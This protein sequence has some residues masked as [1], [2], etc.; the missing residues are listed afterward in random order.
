[1]SSSLPPF[2][3]D[4]IVNMI[5]MVE[6]HM[7]AASSGPEKRAHVLQSLRTSLGPLVYERYA[8]MIGI[9]IDG[10]VDLQKND[11]L[12]INR[13]DVWSRLRR[14]LFSCV[15]GFSSRPWSV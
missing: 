13:K 5:N 14:V 10:L 11:S 12:K 7:P 9:T 1:M 2:T 8:P 15:H 4:T 6:L 3:F